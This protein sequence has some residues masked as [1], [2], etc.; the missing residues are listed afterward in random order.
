MNDA[1]PSVLCIACA[2][3][4]HR[5]AIQQISHARTRCTRLKGFSSACFCPRRFRPSRHVIAGHHIKADSRVAGSHGIACR[6][7]EIEM[8][9]VALF[10]CLVVF[11]RLHQKFKSLRALCAQIKFGTALGSWNLN[12]FHY[13]SMRL[14]L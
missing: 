9:G 12:R 7:R 5:A 8:A 1:D 6:F 10:V 2:L 13:G 11:R 4:T 3:K 14:V